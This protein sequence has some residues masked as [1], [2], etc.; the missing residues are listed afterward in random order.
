MRTGRWPLRTF[1][2]I[3]YGIERSKAELSCTERQKDNARDR[4]RE[5]EEGVVEG[6]G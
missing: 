5:T 6:H 2:F 4:K 1:L 3:L